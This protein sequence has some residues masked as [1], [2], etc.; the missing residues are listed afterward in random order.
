ML[1]HIAVRL[2]C[3]DNLSQRRPPEVWTPSPGTVLRPESFSDAPEARGGPPE[4]E[5]SEKPPDVV[6]CPNS[7]D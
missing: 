1:L 6:I 7:E 5:D 2:L 4:A 3:R